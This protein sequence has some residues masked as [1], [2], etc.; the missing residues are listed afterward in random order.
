MM[1]LNKALNKLKNRKSPGPDKIHNEMLLQ[2]SP[3]GKR[4]LLHLINLSWQTGTVP[5]NWKNSIIVPILKKD[6]PPEELKSYR[7][8][9]LTSCV[10]KLT[11]R[12]INSRL[13]WWLESTG[14]LNRYQAGFRSGQ[15]TEDQLFRLTQRI[16]DGFQEGKHTTAI[17]VD[18]QQAYDR[19]WR[20]GLLMK[21]KN[22]GIHGKIY[23]WI[24]DYLCDRTTS[25]KI[26]N[27]FSSKEVQEEGL[28]QGS[29][30]SCTLFLI[31]INDLPSVLQSEKA[32]YADDL[33][34]WYTSKHLPI[35]SNRLNEDLESLDNFCK[36]WKLKVN[37]SKTVYSIFTNSSKISKKNMKLKI[38]GEELI[39][40]NNPSYLGLQLDQ[41][42][43]LSKHMQNVKSK[44]TK[45]LQLVKRLASTTWGA[46][47]NTL[48]QLYLG[49]IR[50]VM[51]YCLPI[52]S[53]CSKTTLTSLDKVQNHAT[54]HISGGIRSTP[55]AVCEIHTNV[56]PLDLRREASVMNMVE[57]YKRLDDEH[58]NKEI[59]KKWK[60]TSRIKK[61]SVLHIAKDLEH[62]H[63]L[64]E[65]R[66]LISLLERNPPNKTRKLPTINCHLDKTD[67]SKSSDPVDL[68]RVTENTIGQFPESWIH[69]YTDGSAHKGTTNAGYGAVIHL[70][71]KTKIELSNPCGSFCSNFE[72]EATAI[73]AS[74]R[75]LSSA[76]TLFPN[77]IQNSVIFS[78]SKSVLE[79]LKNDNCKNSSLDSLAQEMNHFLSTH[80]ISLVLQWIPGHTNIH[81]N[82]QA[83]K[84]AKLG[85][86]LPQ[87]NPPISFQTAKQIIASNKQEEWMNRWAQGETGR[88]VFPH[89]TTPANRDS[90]N[91]LTRHQ[92][93]I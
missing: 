62:K 43:T 85:A 49:Y 38:G 37:C 77:K 91:S 65:Q 8:I 79:A 52:Q 30:L 46:D 53:I 66:E 67:V 64:P 76:F 82:E 26:N 89:M 71:D 28:P 78:D 29:C 54:R 34:I 70:P 87:P 47:K 69:I 11:E 72:A 16:I 39:K 7:P 25:T 20:K 83:D 73:E 84:L 88:C 31:Y 75:Q 41:R 15:R 58:P 92:Q 55:I 24:K 68:K 35:A 81:G 56:E 61:K 4:T 9:S 18:L 22:A 36:K 42:L 44:C 80:Q 17:F 5:R 60:H 59:V 86:S 48:R 3:T 57:R 6:K 23:K 19:V 32:M 33:A 45:R 74:L 1:E 10:S 27:S 14:F 90:V 40:E 50:S 12:M 51:E 13:Y 2:L 63:H 21:M 93:V